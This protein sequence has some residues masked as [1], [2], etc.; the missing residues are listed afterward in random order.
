MAFFVGISVVL[1][2]Y[3]L[4]GMIIET[5]GFILLFGGFLP[6]TVQ[7]IRRV[8]VIGSVLNLPII[9]RLVDKLDDGRTRV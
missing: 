3:P 1:I 9:S 5:Y 2:G 4:V 7:F 8:P 6:A